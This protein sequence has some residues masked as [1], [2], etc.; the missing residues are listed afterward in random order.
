MKI[1]LYNYVQPNEKNSPGGGVTVYLR[2]LI[3]GLSDAGHD[4]YTL[5]AGDRYSLLRK[6]PFIRVNRQ[7]HE[8]AIHNSPN[9]A[10]ARFSFYHPEIYCRDPSLDHIPDLIKRELHSVDAFH[11]HNIE[12]LTKG[13][14]TSLRR[15]FPE[16][17]ILYSA[18]NYSTLC[19]QVNL[20]QHD[21]RPC[22]NFENGNAC[23][24][25]LDAG[26]LRRQALLLGRLKTPIKNINEKFP[27]AVD[28]IYL[29]GEFFLK[30]I[31]KKEKLPIGYSSNAASEKFSI[32]VKASD[33]VEYRRENIELINSCFDK[34][35]AVSRRTRDILISLGANPSKVETSYIGTRHYEKLASCEKKVPGNGSIHLGYLGYATK[36]KGFF[37]FLDALECIPPEFLS[38]IEITVA[39]R[40]KNPADLSRLRE[41]GGRAKSLNV[42]N[43]F[44]HQ[45]IQ[46]ILAPVTL[47]IVPPLWEDNLPQIAIEFV[48]HGVPILTS[49]RGGAHE[50][51]N[52]AAYVF[53]ADSANDATQKICDILNGKLDMHAFWQ[54]DLQL[55][56]ND[57]HLEEIIRIYSEALQF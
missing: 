45:T 12:G 20:W 48:T 18:H 47:G 49:D 53:S 40:F 38:S 2:N 15:I 16:S 55:K 11:F 51:A 8:L 7:A 5:S 28:W 22:E 46:Q 44:N 10:P 27:K 4:V 1:V 37:F 3:K 32:D 29:V 34:T 17:A 21:T 26:D 19:S 52:N 14:F 23:L 41:I 13:F 54:A 36:Q 35:L 57:T 31:V 56:S 6:K 33:F 30:K 42:Y 39:A 9:V 50:I 24:T 25:C 43:G